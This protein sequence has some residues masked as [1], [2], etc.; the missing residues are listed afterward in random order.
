[1]RDGETESDRRTRNEGSREATGKMAGTAF[2]NK[3]DAI[4]KFILGFLNPSLFSVYVLI[5]GV[6]GIVFVSCYFGYG[7]WYRIGGLL[8][9]VFVPTVFVLLFTV[10]LAGRLQKVIWTRLLGQPTTNENEMPLPE[11]FWR[12]CLIAILIPILCAKLGGK[13]PETRAEKTC[14]DCNPLIAD[15][16]TKKK[17][18]GFYPTNAVDLVKSNTVLRRRY[19]F[20]YGQPTTNG[21]DWTPDKVVEAHVSLFVTTNSFQCI[22]PIEKISPVSFSSFYVFSCNSEHPVWNKVLLHWSPLGA[23]VDEP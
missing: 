3:K 7:C 20:Y 17:L 5:A 11:L 14:G 1:M 16:Q 8:F 12:A 21:V 4:K 9:V 10:I 22:V 2:V 19:F 13:F 23:Y 6:S 18:L 15:L